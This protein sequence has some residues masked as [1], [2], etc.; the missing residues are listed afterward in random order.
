MIPKNIFQIYHDK[1]IIKKEI[2][3]E[4]K[5]INPKYNYYLYDFNDGIEFVKNNFENS[6]ADKIIS[7][8]NGLERY[9]HKSDLL[10][11]CLLYIYGGVYVD[12]DLKQKC[13]LDE[14]ISLSDNSEMIT[15]FGISG[16]VIKMS[17]LEIQNNNNKYHPII[18]NGIIFS[19][20][21]N[22]ILFD[23]IM[24]IL[25]GPYKIRHSTFIYFFHDYLKKN[26]IS[27]ELKPF[28]KFNCKDTDV[29]LL[30]EITFEKNGKCCFIDK[31][32]NII[33]YSN[34][35]MNKNEY[36]NV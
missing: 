28:Q 6:F 25:T 26:S 4:I 9:A 3:D 22:K 27:N 14:I 7:H 19:I 30:K 13:S 21:S 2:I 16:N 20:P 10:R 11:Y 24:Y 35:F 1:T 18:S 32:K 17:K 12:V 29:Y 23:Q 31:E 33:M 8:L 36:L 15:S 34:N 5:N